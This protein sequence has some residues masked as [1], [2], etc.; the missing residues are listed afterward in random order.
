MGLARSQAWKKKVT[1]YSYL[2]PLQFQSPPLSLPPSF[3]LSFFLSST[4]FFSP[5]DKEHLKEEFYIGLFK[6]CQY[7]LRE[8]KPF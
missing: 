2:K 5:K 7:R 6:L 3:C 1:I 8:G 4:P